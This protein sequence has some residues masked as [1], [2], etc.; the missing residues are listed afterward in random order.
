MEEKSLLHAGPLLVVAAGWPAL[1]ALCSGGPW[2][3]SLAW[4]LCGPHIGPG[5]S[6]DLQVA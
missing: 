1:P 3:S 2:E 5:Q 6:A 4:A